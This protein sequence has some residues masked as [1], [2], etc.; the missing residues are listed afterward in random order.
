MTPLRYTPLKSAIARFA[1]FTPLVYLETGN[2]LVMTMLT[3]VL[4]M[5]TRIWIAV[6]NQW[7]IAYAPLHI[8]RHCLSSK[9]AS[10]ALYTALPRPLAV[11]RAIPLPLA[12]LVVP[13]RVGIPPLPRAVGMP[14]PLPAA[15]GVFFG[16][17]AG[18]CTFLNLLAALELGGLST[19]DVSVVRKVAS[20]SSRPDLRRSG[21][22]ADGLREG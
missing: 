22:L 4:D 13:P 8:S 1:A 2:G 16:V 14:L 10:T 9:S 11:P 20:M 18:L 19:N 3:V 17:R 6:M 5:E 15:A 21:R 12:P 7:Y